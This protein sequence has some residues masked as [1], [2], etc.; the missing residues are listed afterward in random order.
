M[1]HCFVNGIFITP[2]K[3]TFAPHSNKT[4]QVRVIRVVHTEYRER[5]PKVYELTT[6]FL[7][8]GGDQDLK[9]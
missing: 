5:H 3:I 2:I 7:E 6:E 8:S 4:I 9:S 1:E